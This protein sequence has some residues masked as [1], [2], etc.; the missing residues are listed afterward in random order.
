MISLSPISARGTAAIAAH[1][2]PAAQPDRIIAGSSSGPGS[3]AAKSPTPVA[4]VAPTM[5][6]PSPPMFQSPTRSAVATA[7]P[8]STRGQALMR[9]L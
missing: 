8:V 3:E 4:A 1:T 2:A 6:W 5:S 9:V 7:S